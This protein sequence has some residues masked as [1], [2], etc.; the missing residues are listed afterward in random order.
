MTRS[1]VVVTVTIGASLTATV[2][3]RA[4]M[5]C[6]DAGILSSVD[7]PLYSFDVYSPAGV[8]VINGKMIAIS[9]A[10]VTGRYHLKGSAVQLAVTARDQGTLTFEFYPRGGE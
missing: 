5:L 6:E 10:K 7:P 8:S 4:D 3:F 1:P 2:Y 9:N